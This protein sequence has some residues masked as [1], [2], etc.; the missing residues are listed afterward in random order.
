[1]SNQVIYHPLQEGIDLSL[2]E[3]LRDAFHLKA[4]D[5]PRFLLVESIEGIAVLL[6]YLVDFQVQVV[7]SMLPCCTISSSL[8]RETGSPFTRGRIVG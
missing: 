5:A 3:L 8:S 6:L 7:A 4:Q 2:A 1:M